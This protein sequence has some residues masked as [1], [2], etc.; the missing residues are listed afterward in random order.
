[1]KMFPI[2]SDHHEKMRTVR[3]ENFKLTV[4]SKFILLTIALHA[5]PLVQAISLRP[6]EL[7]VLP[8]IQ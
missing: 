8:L 6:E 4:N 3:N 1:M 5:Q 2:K 7:K